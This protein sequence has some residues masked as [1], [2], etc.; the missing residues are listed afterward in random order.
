MWKRNS[1]YSMTNKKF[2]FHHVV[3]LRAKVLMMYWSFKLFSFIW[4]LRCQLLGQI[5]F[6]I[7]K[8]TKYEDRVRRS[9]TI[10]CFNI[11]LLLTNKLLLDFGMNEKWECTFQIK[12]LLSMSAS[13]CHVYFLFNMMIFSIHI[14]NRIQ[15]KGPRKSI[16]SSFYKKPNCISGPMFETMNRISFL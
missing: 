11:C 2:S 7:Q 8:G 10:H 16:E 6:C 1:F 5:D 13:I 14:R 9:S 15:K 3:L 4:G 12:Y